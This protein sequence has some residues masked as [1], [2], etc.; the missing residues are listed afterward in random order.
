M[1]DVNDVHNIQGKI[2]N[3][4]ER[5]RDA[6]IDEITRQAVT[7]FIEYR[8]NIV[9][10]KPTTIHIDIG[11][12]NRTIE[13]YETPLL[14]MSLN[15][16][17]DFKT[18]L[19]TPKN[20]GGYGLD[21]SNTGIYGYS[22]VLKKFF[23]FLHENPKYGDFAF[24]EEINVPDVDKGS[25][26]QEQTLTEEEVEDLKD[27][28]R[29]QRDRA[30]IEFMADGMAR[31]SLACQL[32]VGDV[33][34]LDSERPYFTPNPS[35][36]NQKGVEDQV[37]RL[38][39]IRSQA[40]L[41]SFLN[42]HHPQPDNP[43]AP[44]WPI[45][46]GYDESNPEECALSSDRAADIL[47]ECK[48]RADLDK[49]VNPH[50]FRHTAVTRMLKNPNISERDVQH[51][52]AWADRRMLEYYDHVTDE[53]RNDQIR[54][55]MGYL[56]PEQT[57]NEDADREPIECNNCFET[58][59]PSERFCPR[60]GEPTTDKARTAVQQQEDRLF[61]SV[62]DANGEIA[63]DIVRLRELIQDS[64]KLRAAILEE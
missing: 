27:G 64:P 43:D 54:E 17:R 53:E 25:V 59:K 9:G 48:R 63:E 55:N 13:R 41:R 36:L 1:A 52:A 14:E 10:V 60:C 24:F 29:N 18:I 16:V 19:L 35:G 42:K 4:W 45:L 26:D 33:H 6:D 30:F 22:R 39:I 31:I 58:L 44:L 62:R 47:Q 28:A 2:E 8:R 56:D 38:P 32:R 7:E 46:R 61:E 11:N 5:L 57:Q 49:P 40:E 34:G 12:L 15:D 50:N 23:E 21:P 3:E 20:E 51:R 37:H